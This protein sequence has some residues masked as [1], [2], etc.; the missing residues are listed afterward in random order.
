MRWPILM[1]LGNI[2]REFY[3]ER[4]CLDLDSQTEFTV[5]LNESISRP[6]VSFEDRTA[7]EPDEDL[8]G[9]NLHNHFLGA[10]VVP[11]YPFSFWVPLLK[12]N[13][14]KKGT[15]IIKGLLGNLVLHA[16]YVAGW[17]FCQPHGSPMGRLWLD[18]RVLVT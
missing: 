17:G 13:S 15:L 14:R 16:L 18:G 2:T 7:V 11:F 6:F 12:P 9:G 10:P 5:D 4:H 8:G 1:K 3:R